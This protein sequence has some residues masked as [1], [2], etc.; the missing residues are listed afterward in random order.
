MRSH[1]DIARIVRL[2]AVTCSQCDELLGLDVVRGKS[3]TVR[4][5]CIECAAPEDPPHRV[6]DVE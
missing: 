3:P 1:P 4:M 2:R 5:V 6:R